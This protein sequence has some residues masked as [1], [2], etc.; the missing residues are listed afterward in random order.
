MG[1]KPGLSD[2]DMAGIGVLAKTQQCETGPLVDL[3]PPLSRDLE[4]VCRSGCWVL[5]K[6]LPLWKLHANP[7]GPGGMR[8]PPATENL[9]IDSDGRQMESD[10]R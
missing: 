10:L 1:G 2:E 6:G 5:P 9:C 3:G 7:L 8:V 4:W